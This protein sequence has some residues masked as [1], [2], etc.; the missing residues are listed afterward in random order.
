MVIMAPADEDECRQMLYTAT[1]HD[2]PSAVRYPRGSGPGVTP[3]QAMRA[4]PI[5]K[6]EIRRTGRRIALLAFGSMVPTAE[7]VA[8]EIDATVANMRFVKPLDEALVAELA[9]SHELLVTL[10]EN[11]VI[12]GVGSEVSRLLDALAQRPRLL[13]LGLPDR[14]IDHGDQAQ[15]LHSVGLDA[16][17][18]LAAIKQIYPLNS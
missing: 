14:F 7:Q 4:L 5:G 13:R 8:E 1:C 9:A 10:E 11:A 18:V 16:E 3:N 17:G 6:G 12:G 2:G 15:L